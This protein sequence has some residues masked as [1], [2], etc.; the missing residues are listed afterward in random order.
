MSTLVDM[1]P[2]IFTCSSTI[3]GC[4]LGIEVGDEVGLCEG[5]KEGDAFE[6]R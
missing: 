4:I 6:K 3:D 5:L 1:L 2:G